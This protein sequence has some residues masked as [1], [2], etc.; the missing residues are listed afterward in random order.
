MT[1]IILHSDWLR[2]AYLSL[3]LN[4]ASV[5]AI[6]LVVQYKSELSY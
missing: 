3:I 6:L 2:A 5:F 1:E 4:F